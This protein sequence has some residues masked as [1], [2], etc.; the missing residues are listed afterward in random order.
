MADFF[1]LDDTKARL[2]IQNLLLINLCGNVIVPDPKNMP[3]A[4]FCQTNNIYSI[5]YSRYA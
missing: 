1:I 2:F 5:V 3:E 4:V